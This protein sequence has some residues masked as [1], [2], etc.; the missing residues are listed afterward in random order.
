MC[1][2]LVVEKM[3]KSIIYNIEVIDLKPNIFKIIFLRV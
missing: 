1:R 3:A 2:K